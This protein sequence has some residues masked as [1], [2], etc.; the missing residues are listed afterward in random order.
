M[1]DTFIIYTEL[2]E[3]MEAIAAEKIAG[4]I[5]SVYE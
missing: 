1:L 2:K 3:S 5:S 4:V